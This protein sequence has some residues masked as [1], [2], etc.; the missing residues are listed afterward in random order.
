[1]PDHRRT[2][3]P[4][5]QKRKKSDEKVLTTMSKNYHKLDSWIAQSKAAS[6]SSKDSNQYKDNEEK[7]VDIHLDELQNTSVSSSTQ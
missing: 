6:A 7:G 1:M 2:Y 5:Y 4:G 3:L